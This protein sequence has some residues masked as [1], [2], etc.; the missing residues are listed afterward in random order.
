MLKAI[1]AQEDK[2][3]AGRKAN[4]VVR[5]LQDMK[6]K[7]AAEIVRDGIEETLI[8]YNFR[9]NTEGVSGQITLLKGS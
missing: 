8:C 7:R 5:K 3:E 6:L 1:H 9:E 4:S 2:K